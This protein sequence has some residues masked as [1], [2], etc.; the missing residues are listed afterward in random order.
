MLEASLTAIALTKDPSVM[1]DTVDV[2]VASLNAMATIMADLTVIAMIII[3]S[4]TVVERSVSLREMV[5][6]LVLAPLMASLTAMAMKRDGTMAVR[7]NMAIVGHDMKAASPRHKASLTTM[8]LALVGSK[9]ICHPPIVMPQAVP[10][11]QRA[12]RKLGK[13]VLKHLPQLLSSNPPEPLY[14]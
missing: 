9:P 5:R 11:L 7:K 8:A 14:K 10:P 2:M 3:A 13:V 6:S 4:R 1:M 12:V